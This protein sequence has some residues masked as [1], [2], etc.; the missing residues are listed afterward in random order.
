M[1]ALIKPYDHARD[2]AEVLLNNAMRSQY[3]IE[4]TTKVLSNMLSE[5]TIADAPAWCKND[6]LIGGLLDAIELLSCRA[7]VEIDELKNTAM[8]GKK[9]A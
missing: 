6:Y 5:R 8:M 3:A 4:T 7:Y 9:A 1:K 2:H